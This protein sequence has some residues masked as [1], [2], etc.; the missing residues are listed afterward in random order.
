MAIYYF[1]DTEASRLMV[2]T[3]GAAPESNYTYDNIKQCTLF[4]LYDFFRVKSFFLN[5]GLFVPAMSWITA[6]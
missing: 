5:C 2:E 6:H 3:P 1:M 4:I